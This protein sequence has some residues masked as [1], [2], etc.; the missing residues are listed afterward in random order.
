[1]TMCP[2][3]SRTTKAQEPLPRPAHDV[4]FVPKHTSSLLCATFLVVLPSRIALR[5]T[6][7]NTC[8]CTRASGIGFASKII[9]QANEVVIKETVCAEN[10]GDH[11]AL[12]HVP[13]ETGAFYSVLGRE[14]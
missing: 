11:A 10:G 1:M 13:V 4:M 3:P 5:K 6:Q 12:G 2:Q 9:V 8:T 14:R 7:F